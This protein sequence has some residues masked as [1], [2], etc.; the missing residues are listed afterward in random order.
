MRRHLANAGSLAVPAGPSPDSFVTSRN[1]A[2]P[3]SRNSERGAF[4]KSR[5]SRSSGRPAWLP[6]KRIER[7]NAGPAAPASASRVFG[8]SRG[9][10]PIDR[11]GVSSS[12]A[13]EPGVYLCQLPDES[14]AR[15]VQAWECNENAER[16][17]AHDPNS[18]RGCARSAGVPQPRVLAKRENAG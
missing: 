7:I 9:E 16:R 14:A 17:T 15:A 5:P 11:H 10:V 13:P 6:L 1:V 8:A 4:A 18:R 2:D 3:S 12:R